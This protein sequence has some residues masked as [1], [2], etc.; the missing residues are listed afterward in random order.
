MIRKYPIILVVF[1][2][3]LTAAFIFNDA[4]GQ[5]TVI[6]PKPSP[7]ILHLDASGNYTVKLSDVATVTGGGLVSL[8]PPSFNYTTLGAQ[9]VT[10]TVSGLYNPLQASFNVPYGMA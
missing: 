6:T 4:E 7:I 5:G 10:V 1:F 8:S 9:T 3:V 2:L